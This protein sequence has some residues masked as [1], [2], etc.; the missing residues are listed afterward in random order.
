MSHNEL[1][2]SSM[3]IACSILAKRKKNGRSYLLTFFII[4]LIYTSRHDDSNSQNIY[5]L[6]K[7]AVVQ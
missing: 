3:K 2:S 1:I 5:K 7:R 6:G 4:K